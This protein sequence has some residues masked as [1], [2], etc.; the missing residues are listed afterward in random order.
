MEIVKLEQEIVPELKEILNRRFII[1]QK[2][3]YNGPIGRRMLASS[4]D[5]GERII[6]NEVD[7]LND[8]ELIN[9]NR[10]GV[11]ITEKGESILVYLQ[12]YIHESKGL[13]KL[14]YSIKEAL[15]IK[16]VH[17]V[18]GN[19]PDST[20]IIKEVGRFAANYLKG[21]VDYGMTIAITGGSTMREVVLAYKN[22]KR[23]EDIMVVPARGG[24]GRKVETQAS[25]LAAELASKLGGSYKLLHVPDNLNQ[26]ALN[27]L[28]EDYNISDVVK[29]IKNA[30]VLLYGIGEAEHM[31]YERGVSEELIKMIIE[32]KAVGEALG[33]YYDI[34]GNIIYHHTTIGINDDDCKK[35][36]YAIAV[37]CGVNKAKAI[38]GA[39]RNKKNNIL[40][41]DEKT[42]LEI[43]KLLKNK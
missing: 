16:D 39:M 37:A 12:N 8:L 17:V 31:V 23:Y 30:D 34:H 2:I 27:V 18:P 32:K 19:A 22:N 4:L 3:K 33:N 6:R 41:T 42:A 10:D 40:V 21:I 9:T 29:K 13:S 5:I 36:K 28:M 15:G 7:I 26:R 24:L 1:L 25:T 11:S 43:C 20:L 38:T 14:E 35:I